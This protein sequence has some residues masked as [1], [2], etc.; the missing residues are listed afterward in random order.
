M[1][2]RYS[3]IFTLKDIFTNKNLKDKIPMID[4][5][6]NQ[7]ENIVDQVF[8]IS[9]ASANRYFRPIV[10]SKTGDRI[11]IGGTLVGDVNEAINS[12]YSAL[13]S[14]QLL[15][16]YT[17]NNANM[18]RDALK[19]SE[20]FKKKSGFSAKL[21][22]RAQSMQEIEGMNKKQ[23]Q[24]LLNNVMENIIFGDNFPMTQKKYGVENFI[25]NNQL[26]YEQNKLR[27]KYRIGEV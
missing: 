7:G 13:M 27:W 25:F 18:I 24:A 17:C 14:N 5:T 2:N 15:L 11:Q 4:I 10:A 8:N 22:L 3:Q 6:T 23:I 12:V 19:E 16:T 21:F 9:V 1:A 20:K 26:S